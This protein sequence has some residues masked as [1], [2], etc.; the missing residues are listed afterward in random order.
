M[1]VGYRANPAFIKS[2]VFT[3]KLRDDAKF[4]YLFLLH[5]T[6]MTGMGLLEAGVGTLSDNLRWPTGRVAD[7]MGD[8]L[9]TGLIHDNPA[10]GVLWVPAVLEDN[11]PKSPNAVKRLGKQWQAVPGSPLKQH[12][13][14]TILATL[15]G[16]SLKAFSVAFVGRS[17][18][19]PKEPR[20]ELQTELQTELPGRSTQG[21]EKTS[22][23][24]EHPNIGDI[25]AE[26]VT[27]IH[28]PEAS[29]DSEASLVLGSA[30]TRGEAVCK[31]RGVGNSAPDADTRPADLFGGALP[32]Q[33]A[34]KAPTARIAYNRQAGVFAGILPKDHERW[35]DTYPAIDPQAEIK[36]AELWLT[37]NPRRAPVAAYRFLTAWMGKAHEIER[38]L[39]PTVK[40][41]REGYKPVT[42][43]LS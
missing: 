7:A 40:A 32:P 30:V 21:G 23:V 4:L 33:D 16:L 22:E 8:L 12:V 24:S 3:E 19:L 2:H 41:P 17:Q 18:G 26:P 13:A 9:V 35:R 36:K 37:A 11:P 5:H 15:K 25:G 27:P 1:E 14:D 6:R 34:T 31:R 10:C 42:R 43:F 20:T 29:K 28:E 38:K 39:V